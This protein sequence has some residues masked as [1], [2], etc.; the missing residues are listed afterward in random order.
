LLIVFVPLAGDVERLFL[1][2]GRFAATKKD[3]KAAAAPAIVLPS[4]AAYLLA[5]DKDRAA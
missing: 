5:D 1:S 2:Q 4:L 3:T